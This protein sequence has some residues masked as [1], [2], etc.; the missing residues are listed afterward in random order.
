M[1]MFSPLTAWFSK[2]IPYEVKV[3]WR[4]HGGTTQ[5]SSSAYF[6]FVKDPYQVDAY[7]VITSSDGEY[8]SAIDYQWIVHCLQDQQLLD[9]DAFVINRDEVLSNIHI[10]HENVKLEEERKA[11]EALNHYHDVDDANSLLFAAD[12][13]YIPP[14]VVAIKQRYS[15]AKILNPNEDT[16]Y[17]SRQKPTLEEMSF[18]KYT[19]SVKQI[20]KLTTSSHLVDDDDDVQMTTSA[21]P[22][23]TT[24]T[25]TTTTAS[26][27]MKSPTSTT[28]NSSSSTSWAS[29]TPLMTT[30]PPPPLTTSPQPMS[31]IVINTNFF[32]NE[33]L[34]TAPHSQN[35][36][37][38]DNPPLSPISP[39]NNNNN[40]NVDNNG[41]NDDDYNDYSFN[42]NQNS[43]DFPIATQ[44]SEGSFFS[45]P[46]PMDTEI[47]DISITLEERDDD[48]D[49]WAPLHTTRSSNF[50]IKKISSNNLVDDED[51][52]QDDFDDTQYQFTKQ[53]VSRGT[54]LDTPT[55]PK[56]TPQIYGGTSVEDQGLDFPVPVFSPSKPK[57]VQQVSPPSPARLVSIISNDDYRSSSKPTTPSKPLNRATKPAPLPS[58]AE[59]IDLD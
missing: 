23:T 52:I 8:V 33:I 38:D 44:S 18:A 25:T 3:S 24:T 54:K 21:P 34:A 17:Q 46:P 26:N 32:D 30:N 41:N 2:D 31:P 15:N 20:E 43:Q 53:N 11:K 22:T 59:V 55:K 57:I 16:V 1:Q 37:V 47:N 36:D 9:C 48:G 27:T 40:N 12:C 35:D 14:S 5:T 56:Q 6:W 29:P 45:R 58:D 49:N 4:E 19:V 10:Y 51:P 28:S 50:T 39:P 7:K 42:D 13:D